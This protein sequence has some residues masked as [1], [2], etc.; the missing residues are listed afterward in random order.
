M[1]NI[2]DIIKEEFNSINE[3]TYKVYHGTNND[4]DNFDLNKTAQGIIWFTDDKNRIINQTHGGDG[5]KIII[6]ALITINNPAGWDEYEKLGLQQ[7]EDRGY[8][9]I[10]L[11]EDDYSDYIVFDPK[12]IKIINKEYM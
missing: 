8:D 11:P 10:I 12:N 9:G 5:N 1:K 6:T 3:N 7:I 2:I 4:F